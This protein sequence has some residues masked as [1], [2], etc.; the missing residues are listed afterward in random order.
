MNRQKV[1]IVD[2]TLSNVKGNKIWIVLI[3]GLLAGIPPLVT[4]FYLPAFPQMSTDLS[5]SA[6][7]IQLSL[8]SCLIGMALGQLVIGPLSDVLGRKIPL[9][10]SLIIFIVTTI[11]CAF[12]PSIWVFVLLRFF[13]GL[14]GAGG[15][16]LSRAIARDLYGGAELTKFFAM[17]MMVNGLAPILAPVAGGQLLKVTDWRGIFIVLGVFIILIFLAVIFRLKESLPKTDR[18]ESGLKK[19]I[20][21]FGSLFKDKSFI[22]YVL[23]Q[24]FITGGFF[25]YLSASPFVLQDIYGLSAQAYSFS[26]AMNGIGIVIASQVA[27]KLI[28][29]FSETQLLKFGVSLSLLSSVL[30][31]IAIL[32]NANI[33][34]VLICFFLIV[35]CMGITGMTT[36]SLA[37]QGQDK[38]FGSASALLGLMP[39][40][41]G[42]I[43]APLVGIGGGG[44][45]LPMAIAIV[46][47]GLSA[48]ISFTSLSKTFEKSVR[49]EK[50]S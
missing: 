1:E 44:T 39:F 24:G 37:M 29:K 28:G 14:A 7:S 33:M 25:A 31:L 9:I 12:S 19:T 18:T 50:A 41:F 36:N 11:L 8:T 6:S 20:L 45:A 48:F 23:T 43:T 15:V 26:F 30:L 22:G 13:Q 27:G 46:I 17:L 2:G 21:T 32:I 5:S 10:V 47:C 4:D 16:V 38:T 42:A 3:L 40:I 35:S 34:F 49:G